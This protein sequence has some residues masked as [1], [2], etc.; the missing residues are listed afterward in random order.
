VFVA[1]EFPVHTL[2]GCAKVQRQRHVKLPTLTFVGADDPVHVRLC[3][4]PERR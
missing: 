4:G 1:I 3:T 2:I